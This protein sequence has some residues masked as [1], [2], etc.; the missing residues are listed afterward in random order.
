MG[1]A[2]QPLF[3][4]ESRLGRAASRFS[5]GHPIDA[6]EELAGKETTP[7]ESDPNK[8]PYVIEQQNNALKSFQDAQAKRDAAAAAVQ[9]MH[10]VHV[11]AIIMD[12]HSGKYGPDAQKAAQQA[13]QGAPPP[14]SRQSRAGARIVRPVKGA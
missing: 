3:D 13:M 9:K 1:S 4:I 7:T 12:A 10:P 5:G 14:S 6:M 11:H 2:A 8:D